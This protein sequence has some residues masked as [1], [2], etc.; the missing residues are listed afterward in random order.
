MVCALSGHVRG[1]YGKVG[2]VGRGGG[3][4]ASPTGPAWHNEAGPRP[5]TI[6]KYRAEFPPVLPAR[7]VRQLSREPQGRNLG[8]L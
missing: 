6:Q 4:E 5:H 1:K 7:G 3:V 8:H 2:I